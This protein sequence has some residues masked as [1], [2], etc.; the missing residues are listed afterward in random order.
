MTASFNSQLDEESRTSRPGPPLLPS[1]NTR[2]SAPSTP[3][4]HVAAPQ[5]DQPVY[6]DRM[7]ASFGSES[8]EGRLA[9]RPGPP[10][11]P[12]RNTRPDYVDHHV[13]S[14]DPSDTSTI[15][16]VSSIADT[17]A[18]DDGEESDYLWETVDELDFHDERLTTML[19]GLT[20]STHQANVIQHPPVAGPS[21]LALTLNLADPSVKVPFHGGGPFYVVTKGLDVG[22]FDDW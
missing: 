22:V 4:R 7:T 14:A 3:S 20:V 6:S 2:P 18:I 17:A 12:P 16:D 19:S 10:P 9:S 15:S 21:T 1:W 8:E 11:L 5:R 13:F